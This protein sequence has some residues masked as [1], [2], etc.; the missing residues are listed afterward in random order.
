MAKRVMIMGCGRVG[1]TLAQMLAARGDQVTVLDLN[2]DNFR[3]L[4]S[5]PK[6]A[7]I[8]ADGTSVEDLRSAGIQRMDV[9]V[10]V[11]STDT[12]NALA[13]QTAQI[14]FGVPSVVCRINDPVRQE[15]YEQLGL[16]TVTITQLT[17]NMILDA[18]DR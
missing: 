14:T 2:A 12:I 9:F 17:A 15:I 6:I 4:R 1:G 13:A 7:A 3:R 10:A 5:N 16:R 11:T 18:M 8:V